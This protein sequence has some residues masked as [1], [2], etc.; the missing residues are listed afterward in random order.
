MIDIKEFNFKK[1]LIITIISI[2]SYFLPLPV[3]N[4]AMVVFSV[5]IL[6]ALLWVTEAIPLFLTSSLIVIL[7]VLFRIFTF[8]EAIIKFADPILILLFGGFLIA[9]AMQDVSL[10]KRIAKQILHRFKNDRYSLL[11]LMFTTAFLSMWISNTASTIVMI[12]I[13][14]GIVAKFG[15]K[16]SNF[17]KATVLGIAYSANIGGTGTILGTPPNAIAV[18]KLLEMSNISVS[19]LD[20]MKATIPITLI[21]VPI[22]WLLLTKMFP[23]P[24]RKIEAVKK[25]R[26]LTQQQKLFLYIFLGTILLWLTTSIHGISSSLIAL[27]SATVLFLV[28]L[29]KLEDLNKINYQ[30]LILFGGGLVLGSAMFS[31]G[32][33][34]FFA[35]NL[36]RLL[37]GYPSFIVILGI[38]IFAISLGALASNTATAAILMPVIIPLASSLNF[39]PKTLAL[40]VGVAVSLD[41]LLP[42]GTPPNAIAYSTGKITIKEMLKAGI[43]LTLISI[44]VLTL[45]ARFLWV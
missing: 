40:L 34:Q 21:L 19:F 2:L 12:P 7:I 18:S 11:A 44:I 8:E 26:R 10:D 25:L 15:K 27:I 24:E 31:S 20:W 22:A 42:V 35:D 3:S 32:L 29:L 17:N 9:R 41:F 4:Q 30:I 23:F 13:A 14:L 36:S 5:L 38:T 1:V 16:M 39:S 45:I 43:F 6:A 33:S 28:K 37:Q